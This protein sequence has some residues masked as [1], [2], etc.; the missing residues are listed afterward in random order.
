MSTFYFNLY[1]FYLYSTRA[2]TSLMCSIYGII[3]SNL[4]LKRWGEFN[5]I[6]FNAYYDNKNKY[7]NPILSLS[8][9]NNNNSSSNEYETSS[10]TPKGIKFYFNSI[11]HIVYSKIKNF[12]KFFFLSYSHLFCSFMCML[13]VH[14][15]C[16]WCTFFLFMCASVLFIF[17]RYTIAFIKI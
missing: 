9:I 8:T 12:F 15:S 3:E 2:S 17:K 16:L 13:C 11:L 6:L 10:S 1:L 4:N 7:F 14:L 5:T